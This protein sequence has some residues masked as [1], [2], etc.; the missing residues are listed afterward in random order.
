MNQ[1]CTFVCVAIC[2]GT[3]GW[4]CI[5]IVNRFQRRLAP[6]TVNGYRSSVSLIVSEVVGTVTVKL[7]TPAGTVNIP[8]EIVTPLLNAAFVKVLV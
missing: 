4:G 2:Y 1:R 6:P 3:N 5:V 7:V 8:P